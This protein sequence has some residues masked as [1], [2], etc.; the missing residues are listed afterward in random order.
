MQRGGVR[1]AELEAEV[2]G[3]QERLSSLR[4]ELGESQERGAQLRYFTT[5]DPLVQYT[6]RA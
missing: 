3:L 2:A 1:V 5:G 4:R 6:K